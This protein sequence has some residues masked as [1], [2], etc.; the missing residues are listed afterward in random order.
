MNKP[1]P[2]APRPLAEVLRKTLGD[3]FAKKGFAS[4]ELVTRWREIVGPEI[5]LHSQPEKIQWPRTPVEREARRPGTLWLKVEGPAAIEIQHLAGVIA[6]R[7]NQFFGWQAVAQVRLR[8]GPLARPIKRTPLP[9]PD[10]ATMARLA[11]TMPKI[12]DEKLREAL[13]RLGAA[14]ERQRNSGDQ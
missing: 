4:V 11:A 6:E 14:L 7:V 10:P 2:S 9:P 12:Q 1:R 5:A 3:A 13:A 8:Q